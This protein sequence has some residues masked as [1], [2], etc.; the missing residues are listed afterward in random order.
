MKDFPLCFISATKEYCTFEK[1]IPAPYIRKKI[2]IKQPIEEA[3]ILICG[4]GFYEL[5]VNGVKITKGFLAPYISVPDDIFYYD[6]YD[7]KNHLLQG[8]NVIGVILGNGMQNAFGGYVWGFD[9]AK[10]VGAPKLALRV[11]VT[12]NT[13]EHLRIETDQSFKTSDSPI[14]FDDLRCGEYYDARNEQENW[15]CPGFDDSSWKQSEKASCPNGEPALCT[16]EP[17]VITHELTP[18]SITKQENGYLYDFGI[19]SAGICRLTIAGH[20]GQKISLE[21]GEYLIDGILDLKNIQFEPDGYVQ[22]D[23][24]KC[25]GSSEETYISSFTYHGF[26]YVFVTGISD[27]QATKNLLTYLVMNSDLKE[28]G[29]FECSDNTINTL[30]TFTRRSTLA[31]FYYFPTDCPHREKNGWTGDAAISA[32]HTLLNLA[33]ENSY[34]EWLRNI[35]KAQNEQGALPGIVPTGGWGYEWGNGPAWDC[36][37]TLLPYYTYIYRGDIEILEENSTAIFRYLHY[38]S[39]NINKEGLIEMGLGDWCTPSRGGHQYKSPLAFTDSVMS[40]DICKKAS[41]IFGV[42]NMD[43]QKSFADGLYKKLRIAV[44]ERLI[45]FDTMTAAGNCQTSQA[46][47]IFYDIFDNGE[48]HAAFKTL[49]RLIEQSNSH[50][51][52]G[53]L[54]ARVIFHVLSSFGESDLAFNL[55]TQTTFPSYG[56]WIARGATSL[57]EDFQPVGGSVS[58]HNHHFFGDISGWFIKCIAGINLNPYNNNVD[59]VNITPKFI[60]KLNFAKGFHI[61]P[62]GKIEVEWKRKLDAI[63]LIVSIPEMV[64]G[65]IM[66]ENN[67]TFEDGL[68]T[69]IA[70]TGTYIIKTIN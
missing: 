56:N 46:M 42:L 9:K 51:D 28:R 64:S 3:K 59:E 52:T 6:S 23:I 57:W 27:E 25:K 45:D 53:I 66:L 36:V 4:L 29:G 11:D 35:K 22:K 8:E 69:I 44:R 24:Y 41:L 21:H 12:T 40:M 55:I 61:A 62:S 65:K 20:R 1:Y 18:I 19:N 31:N 30:Q 60:K 15:S 5:Y 38:L 32:E 48:K 14:Y 33:P 49:R 47:A 54:G 37:L 67:Y 39:K 70:K 13:N 2:E 58:S 43:L 34:K 50:I 16:A 26:Q 10:W 68:S 17:I 63:V 7:V